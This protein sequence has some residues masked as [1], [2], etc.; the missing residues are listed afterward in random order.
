M[1]AEIKKE[2]E[3]TTSRDYQGNPTAQTAQYLVHGATSEEEAFALLRTTA[4]SFIGNLALSSYEINEVKGGGAFTYDVNYVQS[5]SSGLDGNG[6]AQEPQYGFNTGSASAKMT[7]PL[8]HQGK[9]PSDTATQYEGIGWNGEK[10]EGVEIAKANPTESYTIT[11]SKSKVTTDYKKKLVE[12]AFT[13]NNEKFKG[14]EAGEC[15]FIGANISQSGDNDCTI[16]FNFAISLNK[17]ENF[18]I[19]GIEIDKK[20]GW[21]YAWGLPSKGDHKDKTIILTGKAAYVDRVYERKDFKE[22]G[23]GT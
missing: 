3:F 21:D 11:I 22:L 12:L 16:V 18:T 7:T 1:A 19:L 9:Y 10:Y 20:D 15:L 14:W 17:T 5:A 8:S 6:T 13:V 4:P 23:I 2:Q